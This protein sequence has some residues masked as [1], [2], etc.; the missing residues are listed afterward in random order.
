MNQS[1]LDDRELSSRRSEIIDIRTINKLIDDREALKRLRR[2]R[3]IYRQNLE[4]NAGGHRCRGF[5]RSKSLSN[6][7][8][9]RA[10]KFHYKK[11]KKQL[12]AVKVEE[13]KL[14]EISVVSGDEIICRVC[15]QEDFDVENPLV[16]VCKC[17]GGIQFIH[18]QCLKMWVK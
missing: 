15:Y 14:D 18:Y 12:K 9:A 2:Y 4:D 8:S 13:Q 1:L 16:E 11:E 10:D 5:R 7:S 3:N 17:K 6:A